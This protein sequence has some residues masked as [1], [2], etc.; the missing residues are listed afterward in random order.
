MSTTN[1]EVWI[2]NYG[3]GIFVVDITKD[4]FVYL[5][6][7]SQGYVSGLGWLKH[8]YTKIGEL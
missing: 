6:S 7:G 3:G 2:E 1:Q 5:E 8:H 4:G